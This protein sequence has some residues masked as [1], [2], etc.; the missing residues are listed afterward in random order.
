MSTRSFGARIERNIDPK[1][2]RG[3]G[4][5]VDDIPLANALHAAFVRSPHARARIKKLDASIA[6][7]HPGVAAVYTCDDIGALDVAMPL[8][9]PHPSMTNPKTQRP[10]A[11]GD[12]FYVGQTIAMVVAVDRYTAE[13]AAALIE[14]DFEPL[15]IEMD[16]EQALRD[17]APRVHADVP[18]NLA[19]YLVQTSGDPDAA[20]ARAEHITRIK[21]QVDRSTAAPMECRAVAARWDAVSGELTVWDGTQAPISVRGGLASLFQLDED[22]IRV[23]AP[24]VGGGF[25]QKVLLFYPDELLVPLAAMTLGRPVKYIEDRRENFIGSSQERTQIHT[26]ELAALKNGEIIG[27]RDSFLHDTGAFIPYG[28]AVAQVAST[29]IAGPYR[30]PNIWVEFKAIYTPTVQVTPYRGCGRPHACFA[31]ERAIDQLAE[32]LGIDRFEIRRRNFIGE[33]EFPYQREGLLFADGLKVTLDSGQYSKALGMALRELGGEPF[34]AAQ[35]DARADGKYLGLGLACYVEGT[36]LG[37]YEG[38]HIRIHPITGKVY[39]NTGLSTQGQGHDTVFAQ[40]VAD[41]LGVNPE[42]VIVVEGDTKAFD[43]GVAT[44]ASRAAVVSGNAIHKAAITVRHKVLQAAANM[45]EVGVNDID[46]HDSAAWI[47]GSNRFVPLAAIATASNPLRYA[48]NEAAQAATQFAPA[49]KHDGPPLADGQ[50]PG[51]E[52]TEYYSPPQS[53]WAYG[54]HAAIVEVDPQLCTVKIRKY[55]CIHDCGN[56]INPTIVEGQV[57]GGIAQGIGGA[58]YER[59]DYEP[60]GNLSNASLMDFLMP[61]ATEI[62]PVAILHLETPSP[63]NPLGVKGVGEAGCIAVGA[64]VASGVEDALRALGPIKFHHVPL[65]PRMLSEALER[66]GH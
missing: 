59:L 17:R 54:V 24:D 18:N 25:G 51:I 61:Y 47:K 44:F 23:I 30:I 63:L 66:I 32:D 45:L 19:A 52:A 56:M 22:K 28:I 13:D 20:F 11:R 29:S 53:T 36:G 48:F 7:N 5:F 65:T 62:P 26:I 21:V 6:R 14:V 1:L 27:L 12:V 35:R 41:Q 42:E 16:L 64:V 46:L 4:A 58:L 9:I 10:L 2:L 50:T 8:L 37:P 38:G 15:P 31:T 39:V 33:T 60:D 43:W 34:R 55:V 3:E 40:I 49:S 57:L